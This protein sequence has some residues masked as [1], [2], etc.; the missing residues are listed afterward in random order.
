[1]VSLL[2]AVC[3]VF[4]WFRFF[5]LNIQI[6]LSMGMGRTTVLKEEQAAGGHYCPPLALNTGMQRNTPAPSLTTSPFS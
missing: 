6:V 1:M 3:T 2:N 5:T 4:I